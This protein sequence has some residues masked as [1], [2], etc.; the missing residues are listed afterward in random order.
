MI[1]KAK[2][3]VVDISFANFV[4]DTTLNRKFV[5]LVQMH[6]Q[7]LANLISTNSEVESSLLKLWLIKTTKKHIFYSF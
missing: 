5:N 3:R 4:Y 2:A 7:W 1:Y 6:Y